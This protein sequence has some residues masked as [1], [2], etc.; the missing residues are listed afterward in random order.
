[1]D[2]GPVSQL[3]LIEWIYIVARLIRL[4][5]ALD[6][7]FTFVDG[8]LRQIESGDPFEFQVSKN[9]SYNQKRYEAIGEVNYFTPHLLSRSNCSYDLGE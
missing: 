7:L 8:E 9:H 5:I 6:R 1:M 4:Y 3:M 2:I